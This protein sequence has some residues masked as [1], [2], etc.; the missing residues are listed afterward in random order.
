MFR[1]QIIVKS[2]IS[3]QTLTTQSS[4][5]TSY[6]RFNY[7][8]KNEKLETPL[9]KYY[10]LVAQNKIRKDFG[11][12]EAIKLLDD[13]FHRLQNYEPN[14]PPKEITSQNS[15]NLFG[16]FSGTQKQIYNEKYPRGLYLYGDVGSGKTMLM[17]LFYSCIQ[18]N[19][20]RRVHF[21]TFMLDIH[22]RIHEWRKRSQ[23]RENYD[24]IPPLAR[25]LSKEAW[26]LCFDEFQVTDVADAMILKRLFEELYSY[27]VVTIATSNR[28]P[29]DLYL[30]GIQRKSFVPF[31]HTLKERNLVHRIS[32]HIDYR[33]TGRKVPKIYLCKDNM[34]DRKANATLI[35]FFNL[36]TQDDEE[37]PREY[38]MKILGHEFHVPMSSEPTAAFFSYSDLCEKP[39]GAIDF[40]TLSQ[41]YHTVFITDIPRLQMRNNVQA[42]RF[43]ILIDELYNQRAKV[44]CSA[45][46][47]P[48]DL[49]PKEVCMESAREALQK[50]Q[51]DLSTIS[52]HVTYYGPSTPPPSKESYDNLSI[53]TGE[54]E[55]FMF[56]RAV[57]RLTEMQTEAYLS[58]THLMFDERSE[59]H[60]K[61]QRFLDSLSTEEIFAVKK[62]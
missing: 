52:Y 13:V 34:Q 4:K 8:S 20:K 54:E 36:L 49:F 21:H 3:N 56:H 15:F 38:T 37:K 25:Q 58:S 19:L 31:I 43:I 22:K 41:R 55:V 30:G 17:D 11:Q 33:L 40:S 16:L 9:Q 59:P 47:E 18:T 10:D 50:A 57:S 61:F 27:G 46:V 39:F 42:R 35:K 28:I 2:F 14:T 53:F 48:K 45:E 62:Q 60:K 29:D 1:N 12:E 5:L 24:P 26:L 23:T 51:E 44:F 32:S 6:S 7:S